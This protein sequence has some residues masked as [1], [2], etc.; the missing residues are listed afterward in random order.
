[1][2]DRETETE[3]TLN[4]VCLADFIDSG[5]GFVAMP[6]FPSRNLNR[7]SHGKHIHLA[8]LAF[9]NY[10]LYQVHDGISEAY[11]EGYIFKAL[12]IDKLKKQVKTTG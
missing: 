4:T 5:V 1:M 3:P 10:F 12:R 6:Q 2:D 8:K 11:Y 7:S 9:E